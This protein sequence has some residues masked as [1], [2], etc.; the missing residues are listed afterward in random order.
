MLARRFALPSIQEPPYDP[1][2]VPAA[3]KGLAG[4]VERERERLLL[5]ESSAS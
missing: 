5:R 1:K 2:V 4:K 3:E